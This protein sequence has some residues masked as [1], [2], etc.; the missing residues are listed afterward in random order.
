MRALRISAAYGRPTLGDVPIAEVGKDAVLI[1]VKAAGLNPVDNIL[2]A[3][4]KSGMVPHEYVDS[5]DDAADAGSEVLVN[6]T[7]G[8]VGSSVVQQLPAATAYATRAVTTPVATKGAEGSMQVSVAQV[9]DSTTPPKD[10]PSSPWGITRGSPSEFETDVRLHKPPSKVNHECCCR[11]CGRLRPVHESAGSR[12]SRSA[13]LDAGRWPDARALPQPWLSGAVR[14]RGV[15][16]R[17]VRL[18]PGAAQADGD[19]DR[20]R[21]LGIGAAQPVGVG[22]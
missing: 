3:G 19:P 9:L 10:S 15:D 21:A 14:G 13:S 7:S 11:S 22:P 4:A 16:E 18:V 12:Q 20:Q 5:L 17:A 8:R 2:A 6:G 1:P